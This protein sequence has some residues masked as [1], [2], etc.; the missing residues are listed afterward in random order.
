[1]LFSIG[2]EYGEHRG[3][4]FLWFWRTG[5]RSAIEIKSKAAMLAALQT[6]RKQPA[7]RLAFFRRF[8]Y[9]V[10]RVTERNPRRAIPHT[11]GT[12]VAAT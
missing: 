1:V 7:R 6:N 9:R 8:C 4:R 2:L 10:T 5:Q 3:L 11:V 12:A